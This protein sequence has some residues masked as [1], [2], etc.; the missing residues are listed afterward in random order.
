MAVLGTP[1][2]STIIT[3]VFQILQHVL[4]QHFTLEQAVRAPR[5]HHQDLPD[6]FSVEEGALPAPVLKELE[7]RGHKFVTRERIGAAHCI[8]VDP[9]SGETTGVVDLRE[10]GWAAG[11]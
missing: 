2:G 5:V 10:G 4:D 7:A 11:P 6:Q 1:G 3:T 9:E 8:A